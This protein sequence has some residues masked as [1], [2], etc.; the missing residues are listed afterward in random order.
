MPLT[1]NARL[2][3]L[4]VDDFPVVL[5]GYGGDHAFWTVSRQRWDFRAKA[6][7][8]DPN[9]PLG[10]VERFES[11]LNLR[12][13]LT[14][15]GWRARTRPGGKRL[16]R[17]SDLACFATREDAIRGLLASAGSVANPAHGGSEQCR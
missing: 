11:H 15:R 4:T 8:P 6:S 16:P 13:P 5:E 1:N 14:I 9:G 17:G 12:R 2:V 10:T 7:F 3:R